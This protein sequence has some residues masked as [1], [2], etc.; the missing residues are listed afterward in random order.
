[1]QKYL[2]KDLTIT[3]K[4]GHGLPLIHDNELFIETFSGDYQNF[5]HVDI[6]LSDNLILIGLSRCFGKYEYISNYFVYDYGVWNKRS[7]I[8]ASVKHHL[9]QVNYQFVSQKERHI[10]KFIFGGTSK[11]KEELANLLTKMKTE[12]KFVY[13]GREIRYRDWDQ[14]TDVIVNPKATMISFSI[15]T[16]MIDEIINY[17][18][19]ENFVEEAQFLKDQRMPILFD[20]ILNIEI[21][22]TH[23][24]RKTKSKKIKS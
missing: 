19:K 22:F 16:S 10:I 1:M 4:N 5:Q 12:F 18:N 8:D 17:L 14:T 6:Y 20:E 21:D 7:F 15:T 13:S 23:R 9:Q 3:F 24:F 11:G 2:P